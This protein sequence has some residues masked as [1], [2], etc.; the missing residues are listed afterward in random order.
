MKNIKLAIYAIVMACAGASLSVNIIIATT[1]LI[2]GS[3]TYAEPN[4]PLLYAETIWIVFSAII[5]PFMIT[6]FLNEVITNDKQK[7]RISEKL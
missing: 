4:L 3:H 5:Y 1:I 6:D 7:E 2:D